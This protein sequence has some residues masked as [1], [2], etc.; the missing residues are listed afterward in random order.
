MSNQGGVDKE[1]E[2]KK[3]E[4]EESPGEGDSPFRVPPKRTKAS[5]ARPHWFI[6]V[7]SLVVFALALALSV[8]GE[9]QVI[10][11][12]AGRPLPGLCGSR[13][14][15]GVQCPGCGLT[16][17]FINLAHSIS[18]T[19]LAGGDALQ[20]ELAGATK[21]AAG[22]RDNLARA[23]HFNPGGLLL[24]AAMLA[25]I[26]FRSWRLWRIYRGQEN[27]D[28]YH[29]MLTRVGTWTLYAIIAALIGQWAVR[30]VIRMIG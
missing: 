19:V 13:M 24:F 30:A 14:L 3:I 10:V 25:Q 2:D 22:A 4:G 16:R 20:G 9:E 11:P 15:L 17:C 5:L 6:L 18:N 29:P 7:G 23:W 1:M 26:P 27:L 12:V 8:R 21:R 28:G